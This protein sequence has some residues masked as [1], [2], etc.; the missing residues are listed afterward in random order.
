MIIHIYRFNFVTGKKITLLL[1]LLFA[2]LFISCQREHGSDTS[3]TDLITEY[4]IPNNFINNNNE[5]IHD[6][7]DEVI[8]SRNISVEN[9]I[10][11]YTEFLA[12]Q[13]ISRDPFLLYFL[14]NYPTLNINISENIAIQ[15]I[16]YKDFEKQEINYGDN[17]PGTFWHSIYLFKNGIFIGID[18]ATTNNNSILWRYKSIEINRNQEGLIDTT[19]QYITGTE[20]PSQENIYNKN[21]NIIIANDGLR[22]GTIFTVLIEEENK[23]SYFGDYQRYIDTPN[24]PETTIEFCNNNIII[25]QYNFILQKYT[26]RFYFVNGILMKRE[27][28]DNQIETY[29][30]SSGIGEIIVT[31]YDGKLI[32]CRLLERR[33]NEAGYLEYEAVKFPSGTAYEYFFKK[34]TLK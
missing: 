7:E 3:K 1:L 30:V 18:N 22:R 9:N 15:R 12:A 26:S 21:N 32:E 23:Y 14:R 8:A 24:K 5:N 16:S 19:T 11:Y 17:D 29:T 4:I 13:N 10:Y 28:I 33:V 2:L 34:D 6:I 31:D 27:Y 20:I 25:T